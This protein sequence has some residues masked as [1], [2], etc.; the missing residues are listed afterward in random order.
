MPPERAAAADGVLPQPRLRL[1]DP[2]RHER[3][4]RQAVVLGRQALIVDAVPGL[5]QDAEERGRKEVL[6]IPRRDAAIV[7]AQPLQNG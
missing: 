3:A 6:V 1:V 2:Q 4:R 5:V 7:R